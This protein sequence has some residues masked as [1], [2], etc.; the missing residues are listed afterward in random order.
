MNARYVNGKNIPVH[1]NTQSSPPK[2]T[3][4]HIFLLLMHIFGAMAINPLKLLLNGFISRGTH[5]QTHASNFLTNAPYISP[6]DVPVFIGFSFLFFCSELWTKCLGGELLCA[7]HPKLSENI[8]NTYN[9]R[10]FKA[11]CTAFL[12]R[13]WSLLISWISIL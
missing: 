12:A 1:V 11:F 3:H 10:D 5:M 6:V 7:L 13:L 4:T 9:S 8:K 2:L